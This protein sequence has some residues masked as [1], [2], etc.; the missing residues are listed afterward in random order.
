MK[1]REEN[2][3]KKF[4]GNFLITVNILKIWTPETFAIITLKFEALL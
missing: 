3:R 2:E 1:D 4:A